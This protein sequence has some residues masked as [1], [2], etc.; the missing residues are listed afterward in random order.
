MGFE[1]GGRM[2]RNMA[3]RGGGGGGAGRG[4]GRQNTL[5]KKRESP[6]KFFQVLQ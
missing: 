2:P 3:S 5:G 4:E 1:G 6:K